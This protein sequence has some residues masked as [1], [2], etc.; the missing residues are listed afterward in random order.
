MI[1]KNQLQQPIQSDKLHLLF[2]NYDRLLYPVFVGW[3]KII[4][5]KVYFYLVFNT[6]SCTFEIY[7]FKTRYYEKDKIVHQIKRRYL[8][9]NG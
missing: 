1:S 2:I 3:M 9:H 8:L 5:R 4:Y 7:N 6:E